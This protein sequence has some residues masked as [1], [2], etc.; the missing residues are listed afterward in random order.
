MDVAEALRRR[1]SI[2]AYLDRPVARDTLLAVLD[3]ARWSP[4]GGNLQ[5]WKV[6]AVA[7]DEREAV[8]K[9]A[10][11]TLMKN[12][13]GEADEAPIY[14]KPLW[15]PYRTRRFEL[16]E[17][18]YELLGIPRSDKTR[19]L[20]RFSDNY[21]FFGAPVGLFFVIDRR[22]GRGQWAHLG[23][24]MQS[25]ALAATERGLGCCFQESWAMVRK[26]LHRH[27]ELDAEDLLYCGMA[28][29]W[30]DPEAPVNQLRSERVD[31]LE[32]TTLRGL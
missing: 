8:S 19:R 32:F 31:P 16:G 15:E 2:R 28:L 1:I 30:P 10:L 21:R 11:D 18:M 22:L 4:S 24:F 17:A 14:P 13:A 26:T 7:G 27:F 29:G 23:M 20:Q 5:P 25:L 12:P 9:L 3:D 6:V